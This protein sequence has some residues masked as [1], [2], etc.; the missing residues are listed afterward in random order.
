MKHHYHQHPYASAFWCNSSTPCTLFPD[1]PG[2][3][4][5]ALDL[6]WCCLLA[7]GCVASLEKV[8]GCC[9]V[10][11]RLCSDFGDHVVHLTARCPTVILS[12]AR[13]FPVV[14]R[15]VS[16]VFS[17][18]EACTFRGWPQRLCGVSDLHLGAPFYPLASHL[19]SLLLH[20]FRVP[21]PSP[22]TFRVLSTVYPC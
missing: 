5:R 3:F 9:E 19:L 11:A 22:R 13:C 20:E 17:L 16:P 2:P 18:R 10:V 8:Q 21:P 7:G 12:I 4:S 6:V 15:V 14:P 1:V